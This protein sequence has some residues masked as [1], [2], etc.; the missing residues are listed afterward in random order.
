MHDNQNGS[1]MADG[2]SKPRLLVASCV[3]CHSALDGATWKNPTSGAPIVFNTAQPAYGAD[4]GDGKRQGLAGGNFYWVTQDDSYGHN[5]FTRDATLE[6]APG[7]Y[8][9]WDTCHDRLDQP[10][11]PGNPGLMGKSGCQCCHMINDDNKRWHHANDGATVVNS[12]QQ[13]WYRFL[14]AHSMVGNY[15]V[16]GIEDP[17]WEHSATSTSH[18]EYL[19]IPGDKTETGFNDG[20]NGLDVSSFCTGC[21]NEFHLQSPDAA[22][23]SW[24]KHPSDAVLPGSGEYAGYTTYDPLTPVAR[25]VLSAV[26]AVVTPGTDMVM[27]LSCHRAHASPYKDLL[28]FPYEG[29]LAGGGGADGTGCFKCHTAKDGS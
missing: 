1:P 20:A 2:G 4:A 24:V 13:G 27:C 6:W 3:G 23:G 12:L 14:A 15:G 22:G 19:G 18:N 16:A 29:M 21:H 7:T 11:D 17:D 5:I 8:G 25:P 26:S 28:R 10:N 9:C